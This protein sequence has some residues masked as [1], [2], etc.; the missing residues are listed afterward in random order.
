LVWSD[1]EDEVGD[2]LDDAST[3][4]GTAYGQAAQES[5]DKVGIEEDESDR[6]ADAHLHNMLSEADL[7]DDAGSGFPGGVV[8]YAAD[9]TPR[10]STGPPGMLPEDVQ[11][12]AQLLA[13]EALQER[14]D[15]DSDEE[16]TDGE[17]SPHG[18]SPPSSFVAK[19]LQDHDEDSDSDIDSEEEMAQ[20]I[21]SQLEE[22]IV[23][24]AE[25]R[26]LADLSAEAGELFDQSSQGFGSRGTG[27]DTSG[28]GRHNF[29]EE[30]DDPQAALGVEGFGTAA[31]LLA[32]GK[33]SLLPRSALALRLSPSWYR[34]DLDESG[35]QV[36][37]E[38]DRRRGSGQG[39]PHVGNDVFL[40]AGRRVPAGGTTATSAQ[41]DALASAAVANATTSSGG[42]T[43]AGAMPPGALDVSL[44]E[45]R[46]P[47]VMK[48]RRAQ[49][50]NASVIAALASSGLSP[51]AAEKIVNHFDD[52]T[53]G[54]L[55]TALQAAD[56]GDQ[57]GFEVEMMR[58]HHA[59]SGAGKAAHGAA[60]T[61][62]AVDV[63]TAGAATHQESTYV[64]TPSGLQPLDSVQPPE[65][66]PATPSDSAPSDD[67][68]TSSRH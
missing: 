13:E 37:T 10:F 30:E 46:Y 47:R 1:T 21:A 5:M 26:A 14:S 57:V 17:E 32:A 12:I 25:A 33:R 27:S 28:T 35:M 6:F 24:A 29:A 18:H 39:A 56:A 20:Q 64:M 54:H 67:D 48:R 15:S 19:S 49:Q 41:L 7:D 42:V 16:G 55:R 23:A 60:N 22:R 40:N 34:R 44:L 61:G 53:L 68:P 51:A 63:T 59:I 45:E 8:P 65:P 4:R 43:G 50:R 36:H 62:D 66:S 2:L 9:G 52:D 11:A 31:G 38:Q 3:W 58:A